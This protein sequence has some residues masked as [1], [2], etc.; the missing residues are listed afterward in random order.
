VDLRQLEY[1]VAVA[2]ERS[3]SGAA[4]RVRIVQ[5]AVSAAIQKLER[6]LGVTLFERGAREVVLTPAGAALLPEAHATLAS[7]ERARAAVVEAGEELHG[8][9]TIGAILSLA[10]LDVPAL[11]A[12]FHVRF[13]NVTVLMRTAAS[14]SS[15]HLKAIAEGVLD[16]AIVGLGDN[17]GLAVRL[18][19]LSQTPLR[20][21]CPAGHRFAKTGRVRVEDLAGEVFVDFPV[22]WGNR[23]LAD[24]TLI[25]AGVGRD[26]RFEVTEPAVAYGLIRN[27]LAI[28][29]VPEMVLVAAD[30]LVVVDVDGID[31]ALP[32]SLATP[33]RRA[34][35]SAAAALVE[36][37][38]RTAHR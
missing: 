18:H 38:L 23:I 32:L 1:F 13:P 10:P 5:S 8:T 26:V 2:E 15:G 36:D 25:A 27:G 37:I 24:R 9:V 29:F 14:G 4:R 16:L 22:G 11:L 6:D 34:L 19:R 35:P 17:G 33:S 3:F 21:V 30:D 7:A 20:L 12:R 31:L 28:G